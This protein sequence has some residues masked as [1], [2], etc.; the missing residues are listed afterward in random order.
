VV[1]CGDILLKKDFNVT[2]F[3]LVQTHHGISCT[4]I[5]L[6]KSVLRT[7]G[8]TAHQ[9][10]AQEPLTYRNIDGDIVGQVTAPVLGDIYHTH[11]VENPDTGQ[12]IDLIEI[13]ADALKTRDWQDPAQGDLI[14][15]IQVDNPHSAYAAMSEADS[16]QSF[17]PITELGDGGGL[18]FDWCDGQRSI[19]TTAPPFA[20][21]HYNDQGFPQARRFFEEVLEIDVREL[22]SSATGT[23]YQLEGLGG[24]VDVLVS[25]D[26]RMLNFSEFGKRYPGAN[27]FRLIN[28]DID[29]ITRKIDETGLGGFIIPP[30]NGFAFLRGPAGEAIETFDQNF[31]SSR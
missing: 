5:E 2:S 1:C 8:F 22:D 27:H 20:V 18:L 28:Q 13:S 11:Y 12:Q 3:S 9:P 21:L 19:L 29:R 6:T 4:D 24:R 7:I 25:P 17:G 26:T 23:R 10:G 30:A 16:S 14:I 31:G 15:G